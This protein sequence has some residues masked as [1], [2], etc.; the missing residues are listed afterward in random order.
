MLNP[1]TRK[2]AKRGR[3]IKNSRKMKKKLDERERERETVCVVADFYQ[4]QT[5]GE[6]AAASSS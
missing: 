1:R 6:A 3:K 5:G 4:R 2:S